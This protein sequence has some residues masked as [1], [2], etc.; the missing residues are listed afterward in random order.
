MILLWLAF[1]FNLREIFEFSLEKK[2]RKVI[3]NFLLLFFKFYVFLYFMYYSNVFNNRNSP[4]AS[5][6]LLNSM[7][8]ACT[9]MNRS[10]T[11]II[12]FLINDWRNTYSIISNRKRLKQNTYA[13]QSNQPVLRVLVFDVLT[14]RNAV[15]DVQVDE[16]CGQFN[17]CCKSVHHFH[18][19]Q[20]HIHC[21]KY[22]EIFSDLL[23]ILI[24]EVRGKKWNAGNGQ[25]KMEC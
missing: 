20:A 21:H 13:N 17:C 19:M 9:S 7:Q 12:L 16:L 18:T 25:A 24:R 15:R 8:K 4:A 1:E 6:I 22:R 11:L 3:L 10:F 14:R 2:R 23:W 5:R